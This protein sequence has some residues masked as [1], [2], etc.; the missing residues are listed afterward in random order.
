MVMTMT[1]VCVSPGCTKTKTEL[2]FVR[3]YCINHYNQLRK[4]GKLVAQVRQYSSPEEALKARSERRGECLAWT[5]TK[6]QDGYGRIRINDRLESVHRVA[7]EMT[8]TPIPEGMEVDHT[9]FNRA[10]IEPRHLRLANRAQNT[11]YRRGAQPNSKTGIRNVH[12][13]NGKWFVRLKVQQKNRTWGPF[14]TVDEAKAEASR[15]RK[16]FFGGAA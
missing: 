15:R 8:G 1:V 9:C 5:G 10:C 14:G 7:F 6:N 2:K 3:G 16:E 13:S 12:E 11:Q 4:N